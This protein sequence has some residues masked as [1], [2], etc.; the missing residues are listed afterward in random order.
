[1]VKGYRIEKFEDISIFVDR[2]NNFNEKNIE[3]TDH[4]FFRLSEKQRKAFACDELKRILINEIP[5]RV[6]IQYNGNYA[7][8]YKYKENRII[9]IIINFKPTLIRIVTFMILSQEQLPRG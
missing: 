3:C 8:Y 2:I 4:T 1:M 7:A 6:G 5:L 9:K